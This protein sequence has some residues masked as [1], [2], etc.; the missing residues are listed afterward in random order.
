MAKDWQ[1]PPPEP[2]GLE[3]DSGGAQVP[4]PPWKVTNGELTQADREWGCRAGGLWAAVGQVEVEGARGRCGKSKP[5]SQYSFNLRCSSL[6]ASQAAKSPAANAGDAGDA[7]SVPGAGRCPAEGN[8]NP[9]QCSCLGNPSDR[10]AWW[11]TVH[12]VAKS[13][14]RLSTRTHTY[15]CT[16]ASEAVRSGREALQCRWRCGGR[17][18]CPRSFCRA[19]P[20]VTESE[21]RGH[22]LAIRPHPQGWG[23]TR[24]QATATSSDDPC[25]MPHPQPL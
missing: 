15:P 6:W 16:R 13:Q 9:P 11:A 4:P 2:V 22:G 7:G 17:G 12:G 24:T 25:G 18:G 19:S 3:L 14:T 8:G 10:G 21:S 23:D 5:V 1:Q 20:P